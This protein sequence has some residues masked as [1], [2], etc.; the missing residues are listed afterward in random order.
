M[1]I[2]KTTSL[3][4]LIAY[5]ALVVTLINTPMWNK[6]ALI[7]PKVI[8]LFLTA[9]FLLPYLVLNFKVLRADKI[10][11]LLI[12]ISSLL[13]IQYVLVMVNSTAP[14]EQQIY[15][16]TG[17]G[18]GF[19]TIFSLICI[20][21]A[22]ALYIQ[23]EKIDKIINLIT[24]AGVIL[25]FYGI[26][27]S[28]QLDPLAWD[29]KNNGVIGTLGNPNFLSSFLAMAFIP[30]M[31]SANKKKRKIVYLVCLILL[32]LFSIYRAQS[33]QGYIGI[34]IA[35]LV[36]TLVYFW[37]KKRLMF[38][39]IFCLSVFISVIS[40]LGMLNMG[41]FAKYLYKVSV[42]SRGDFWRSAFN[43]A[44]SHPFFGV[45]ID[46]FGDYFLKYRDLIAVNHTFAE[47][48]DSAHNYFLDFAS[49]GGY[50]LLLLNLLMIALT[51]YCFY[52]VQK[53]RNSF[54]AKLTSLFCAYSVFLAQSMISPMNI[55]LVLWQ[56]VISGSIIGLAKSK[57]EIPILITKEK[58]YFG[59]KSLSSLAVVFGILVSV[60]YFNVDR[61]QLLSMK[62]GNGDLAM[63][64]TKMFPESVVR[65]STMSRDLLNSGLQVQSLELARSAV[66]FNANSPA[67]WVL[68]LIN[69][70][71]P[72]TERK[73]AQ[74]KILELD[75]LN[76]Q[77]M[78]YFN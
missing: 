42:Q 63:K 43:T 44:N 73:E 41:P 74:V 31:V 62:T 39:I 13:I 32:I 53:S 22:S 25:A 51:L 4:P 28:Y 8:F 18:F 27:Q 48:A 49:V 75:P 76:K 26:L 15:G 36:F 46:S 35:S 40:V 47:Y 10:T 21:L 58:S 77:V 55:S 45:G 60:P 78:D 14:I 17:R 29:A 54:D 5:S 66:K 34:V 65:Y 68:I 1:V 24:I 9:L 23:R 72:L 37:Y 12:V 30:I 69:P 7:I 64:S 3:Y 20:L 2:N 11:R 56:V 6:D 57:V 67:L 33:T 38:Y 19:I 50:P 61:L 71:A 70:S 59:V 16:R 52:L